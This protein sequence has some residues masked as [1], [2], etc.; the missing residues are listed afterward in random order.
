MLSRGFLGPAA[1]ALAAWVLSGCGSGD[2]TTTASLSK[3][4]FVRK[5]NAICAKDAQRMQKDFQAFSSEHND[6]PNPSRAEYEEF[7]AKVI[8]PNLTH[9]IRT[10]RALG[11]PASDAGTVE[12]ILSA[13]EEGLRTAGEKPELVTRGNA[14]IFGKAIKLAATYG[15]TAC[16]QAY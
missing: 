3:A 11:S 6:N 16:A 4:E 13:V 9:Q 5:A 7:I 12:E 10:I 15:L 8:E 14:E 2:T 1:V